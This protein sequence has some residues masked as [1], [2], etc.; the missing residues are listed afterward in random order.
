MVASVVPLESKSHAY[1]RLAPSGSS[2]LPVK[3][4]RSGATPLVTSADTDTSGAALDAT[5]LP[6]NVSW[7][8]SN[9]ALVGPPVRAAATR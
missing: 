6:E 5:P 8:M 3:F 1:V 7:S 2:T 9:S 4:T